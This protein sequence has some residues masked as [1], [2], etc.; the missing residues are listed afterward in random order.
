M[1]PVHQVGFVH[2][3]IL[4]ASAWLLSTL[5]KSAR[6]RGKT[7]RLCGPPSK[8]LIYG[9]SKYVQ[10]SKDGSPIFE[11]WAEEYGSVFRMPVA[12]GGNQL[13]LCDPKAISHFY[14]KET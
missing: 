13:V 1:A 10:E 7:T 6:R 2:I 5:V 3:A 12:M 9:V 14:S 4:L 11:K 8:S